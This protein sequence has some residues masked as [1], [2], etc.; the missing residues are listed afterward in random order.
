[1]GADASNERPKSASARLKT[2]KTPASP[3]SARSTQWRAR[4]REACEEA[5]VGIAEDAE[6]TRLHDLVRKKILRATSALVL[7]IEVGPVREDSD[8][9]LRTSLG[10]RKRYLWIAQKLR[11]EIEQTK[12][13][14]KVHCPQEYKESGS[15]FEAS[16]SALAFADV[17]VFTGRTFAFEVVLEFED[18]DGARHAVKLHSKLETKLFPSVQGLAQNLRQV[19]PRLCDLDD[20]VALQR[21]LNASEEM[22]KSTQEELWQ[23]QKREKV[24]SGRVASAIKESTTL[25]K[26][27]AEAE[28]K[29][30][31]CNDQLS[32][33]VPRLAAAEK[34]VQELSSELADEKAQR[35]RWEAAAQDA[36]THA[37][38]LMRKLG[39]CF[40]DLA[41]LQNSLEELDDA[42]VLVLV[43]QA[44]TGPQPRLNPN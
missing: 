35:L 11:R 16:I 36:E 15:L 2:A 34:A 39:P 29:L 26:Q 33:L 12:S 31:T 27:L 42:H 19:L 23:L 43:L 7:K 32:Y 3:A 9:H 28:A 18:G 21:S 22:R 41:W 38:V 1:M 5:C 8:W 24:L 17:V 14:D 10:S 40:Q 37:R 30:R 4:A 13:V 44:C 20:K 25:A 6:W